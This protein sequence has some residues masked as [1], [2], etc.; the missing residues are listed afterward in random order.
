MSLDKS[1][2]PKAWLSRYAYRAGTYLG[3]SVS[4]GLSAGIL[5][6]LQASVLAWIVDRVVFDGE[7]LSR[8]MPGLWLMLGLI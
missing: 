7:G 8:A 1:T 5:L 2:E 4:L 6:I 3:L